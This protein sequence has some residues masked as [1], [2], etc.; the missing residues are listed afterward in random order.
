MTDCFCS[1]EPKQNVDR[2][3]YDEE[4]R[5]TPFSFNQR[6]IHVYSSTAQPPRLPFIPVRQLYRFPVALKDVFEHY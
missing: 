1:V 3:K 5:Q 6:N 2:E 4:R